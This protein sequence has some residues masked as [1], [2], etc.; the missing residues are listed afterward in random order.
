MKASAQI[1]LML[2]IFFPQIGN[3]KPKE[4]DVEELGLTLVGSQPLL[5][6]LIPAEGN[7]PCSVLEPLTLVLQSH[8]PHAYSAEVVG[9]FAKSHHRLAHVMQTKEE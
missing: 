4:K 1:S 7:P 5:I 6:V 9:V 3:L 2:T 8:I